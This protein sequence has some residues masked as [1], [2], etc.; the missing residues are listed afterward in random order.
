[1]VKTSPIINAFNAGEWS[2]LLGGRTDIEGYKASSFV[3]ENFIP[4]IQGPAIRRAG[5]GF[6]RPVKYGTTTKARL[7]P[8]V[9]SRKDAVQ[10]EFGDGYCRFFVNNSAVVTGTPT[11]ISGVTA[12]NPV[13]VSSTGHGY[14]NGTEVFVSGISGMME[15][16]NRWFVVAGA[17]AN[18]YELTTIHGDTVDGS[19]YS[20]YLSGGQ[21]DTP[22][23]I[24]SPYTGAQL[25]DAFGLDYVQTG[26]VIY[27]TDR[28]GVIA[29]QKLSRES[30]TDWTFETF[31]P[32]DGP[33]RFIGSTGATV[34]A[35]AASGNITIT[36]SASIF[37][38][39]HVGSIFRI[40]QEII[41]STNEWETGVAYTAGQYVRS[42]GK[43]YKA[44]TTGTSGTSIPAHTTGTVTDGGVEWEYSSPA[45]GIARITA[46]SGTS[47]D[48]TVITTMPQTVVGAGNATTLWRKA[49]WSNARGY[50]TCVSFF[51]ERLV[52]GRKQEINMSVAGNFDSF[53]IDYAGEVLS[54]SAISQPIQSSEANEIVGLAEGSSLLAVTEGAEF[55]VNVQTDSSPLGPNNIKISKQTSYGSAEVRPIRV[56]ENVLFVQASQQKMRSISYDFQVDNFVAPDMTVRAPGIMGNGVVQLARQKEPYE[57]IWSVRKDGQLLIFTFDQTQQVRAWARCII[58][59]TNAV[60]ES[61]SVVPTSDGLRDEITIIV[62]RTINGATRRYIENLMPEYSALD[63]QAEAKYAD[64]LLTYSGTTAQTIYGFDHLEGETLGVLGDGASFPDVIVS[65]GEVAL[66]DPVTKA[67]IGLKYAAR[68][69]SNRS[70]A[71]GNDGTG[72]GKTK[73]ITDVVF[74]VVNTLGGRSGPSEA[75]MD[76]IPGLNYRAPAVPMGTPPTLVTGDVHLS[77]PGGYET[78]ARIWYVNSSMYPATIAAIMPQVSVSEAR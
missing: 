2:N 21:A 18:T 46:Q 57:I 69:A 23:E 53:A 36:A 3:L 15:L 68:Y 49:A 60:V 9:K 64:S 7:V 4:S 70:N 73:R 42:E 77:W 30:P 58:G 20:A 62:A 16:N 25:D 75:N 47:C 54:E 5:T 14:T 24:A 61:V 19:G 32:D 6:V 74:R 76:E 41:T 12:A 50:P 71:A 52:F 48:A 10:I 51:R 44:A 78:D 56:G 65:N 67:Q 31:D 1:M 55:I 40:D 72:Q 22:Y 11:T 34:Y 29:P 17:T 33:W 28:S 27:I 43:E 66:A 39:G 35:S 37:K 26:N 38:A 8:F 13:V 59:G 63:A 45:Y